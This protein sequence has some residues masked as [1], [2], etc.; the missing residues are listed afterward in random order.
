MLDKPDLQNERIISSLQDKYGLY[1]VELAF[2]PLGAD[3]YT[4]VYR[5][6]SEDG[7]PYLVKLRRAAFDEIGVM[8]PRFLSDQGIVHVIA[9]LPTKE[10]RLWA[11]LGAFKLV[12]YPFIEGHNG[13]QASLSDR[14][15]IDLGKALK[16]LHTVRV[17]PELRS[18]IQ[19]EI[20][21]PQWPEVLKAFLEPLDDGALSDPI[22]LDLAAF[23]KARRDEILDLIGNTERLALALQPR[24]AEFVLCHS[25]IHAGNVLIDPTGSLYIVDWDNPTL[26][27]K[28]RDLMFIGGGHWGNGRTAQEEEA[29]FFRGYGPAEVDPIALAYYRYERIVEDM[30]I[31]CE[32]I[33]QMNEGHEDREQSL[34]YLK[35]NFLPNSTIELAYGSDK[36]LKDG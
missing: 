32:R 1:V 30:A 22:A 13:Y 3:R 31:F 26:A 24:S 11:N 10:G 8:L 28:E 4:A 17:P 33:F 14:H 25:D 5:A 36:M 15:W 35:S 23:L 20:Y 18:H 21:S 27:P 19:R 29:L 34:R 6:V 16:S 7:A 9:P 2:L 12:L